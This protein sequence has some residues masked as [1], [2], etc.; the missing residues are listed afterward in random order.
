ME[1]LDF[2]EDVRLRPLAAWLVELGWRAAGAAYATF[3]C[4]GGGAP[5][6]DFDDGKLSSSSSDD[7]DAS[8]SESS[9]RYSNTFGGF[10]SASAGFGLASCVF[11]AS[12]EPGA[13]CFGAVDCVGE[14]SF[15]EGSAEDRES[16]EVACEA[17]ET[18][19]A[20]EVLLEPSLRAFLE[21]LDPE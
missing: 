6:D 19:D 13:V 15:L 10:L 1:V 9:S 5:T 18:I 21:R 16:L 20:V 17:V 14:L 3:G 2:I 4:A 8:D 12:I 7:D 11:D